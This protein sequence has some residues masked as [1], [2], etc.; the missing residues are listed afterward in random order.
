MSDAKGFN[1]T[2]YDGAS[3]ITISNTCKSGYITFYGGKN[4]EK[5][6]ISITEEQFV[7]LAKYIGIEA[8]KIKAKMEESKGKAGFTVESEGEQK[9]G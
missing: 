7:N 1:V 6:E 3:A 4:A 5:F 8:E 9:N 2:V